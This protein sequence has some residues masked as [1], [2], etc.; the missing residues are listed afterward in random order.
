VL[1]VWL[2]YCALHTY[3]HLSSTTLITERR[4]FCESLTVGAAA[5]EPSPRKVVVSSHRVNWAASRIVNGRTLTVTEIE[6]APSEAV[7]VVVAYGSKQASSSTRSTHMYAKASLRRRRVSG[8]DSVAMYRIT[9]Y[10]VRLLMMA[11]WQRDIR[12][13]C[14]QAT[15]KAS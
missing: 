4:P 10:L 7:I 2:P 14:R 12:F 5:S 13:A 15:C 9:R 1:L 11:H 8:R 3:K 6:E